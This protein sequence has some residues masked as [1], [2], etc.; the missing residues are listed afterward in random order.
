MSSLS[1][2]SPPRLAPQLAGER[3]LR[4]AI[5]HVADQGGGAE[6]SVVTLHKT[7]L[8][9]GHQ[10]RLWVGEKRG[11]EPEVYEIAR[12]RPIPGVL[13][14]TRWLEDRIGWQNLYAPW[15]RNLHKKLG[16]D[17]D[18]VH[19]HSLWN[20]R[21]GFADLTGVVRLARRYPMVMT[22]R[23]CWM[24]TGHCACFFNCE[25]W[26]TG[27]GACPDLNIAPAVPRDTTRFNWRRKR[28]TVQRSPLRVTAVSHWLKDQVAQSPIFAGKPVDV[29]HNSIDESAFFPGSQREARAALGVP[30]DAFVV[31]LAG[32]ALEGAR[33]GRPRPAVEA[34][35]RL[36]EQGITALLVGRSASAVAVTLRTPCIAVPFQES[37]VAMAECYR[38]TDLTVVPSEVETFGRVAAESLCCGTPVVAFATGGLTD[39]VKPGTS[40]WLVSPGDIEALAQAIHYVFQNRDE[41]DQIRRKC[42]SWAAKAFAPRTIAEQYVQVYREAIAST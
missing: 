42:A 26:K 22:L 18:V 39:I 15:F 23:D 25:R 28:R 38:A 33:Q 41:L 1:L 6:R 34:L 29:V 16:P 2:E 30:Q 21:L 36:D 4:I 32:Q 10:S 40:G 11:N 13:R 37:Q 5:V 7:L 14:V 8:E 12:E 20:V 9:L 24:L 31:M 27:C 19:V 17:V 35:N 3:P